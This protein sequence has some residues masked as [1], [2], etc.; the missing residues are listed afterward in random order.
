MTTA[1]HVLVVDDEPALREICEEALSGA[2]HAVTLASNGQ[3]A[4][5]KLGTHGFDLV[6]SDL[7][8]PDMNGQDLLSQIRKHQLDVDFLVMTGY[9]TTETAVDIMKNG[10]ADY[11]AKP[12]DMVVV[13]DLDRFHLMA[14]VIDRVPQ[15]GAIAF[16]AT[17]TTFRLDWDSLIAITIIK[18]GIKIHA[19]NMISSSCNLQILNKFDDGFLFRFTEL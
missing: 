13:N 7:R 12:F 1:F 10:A 9:G 4:L 8:M 17:I 16:D 3:D 2:G 19:K 5:S 15:L 6:I 18:A 14:D 11:I